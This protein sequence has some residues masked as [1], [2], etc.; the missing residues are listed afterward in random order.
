MLFV[1]LCQLSQF[2]KKLDGQPQ[3][4]SDVSCSDELASTLCIWDQKLTVAILTAINLLIYVA[5][6]AYWIHFIFI[7]Y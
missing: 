3:W 1:L 5:D 2:N 4:S 7:R 6:M